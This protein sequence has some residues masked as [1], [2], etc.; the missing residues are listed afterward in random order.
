MQT[1]SQLSLEFM[2]MIWYSDAIISELRHYQDSIDA[3]WSAEARCYYRREC[4]KLPWQ[5]VDF[6]GDITP[7]GESLLGTKK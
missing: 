1:L 4:C 2:R 5:L 3:N 7:M 6:W